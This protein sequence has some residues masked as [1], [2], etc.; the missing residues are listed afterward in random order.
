MDVPLNGAVGQEVLKYYS[1][2][3]LLTKDVRLNLGT[4]RH[5][6]YTPVAPGVH[7]SLLSHH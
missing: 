3:L 7:Q 1:L 6:C 2:H 4:G 5:I